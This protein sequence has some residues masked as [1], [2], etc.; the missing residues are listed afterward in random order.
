[1]QNNA[2]EVAGIPEETGIQ[3]VMA[4]FAGKWQRRYTL[5]QM[6]LLVAFRKEKLSIRFGA[7]H[8]LE[9][10]GAKYYC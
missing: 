4:S 3:N 9:F 10:E 8:L 7:M 2:E 1:M 5:R 6:V